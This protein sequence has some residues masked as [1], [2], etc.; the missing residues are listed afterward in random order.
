MNNLHAESCCKDIDAERRK[1]P[2]SN[3]LKPAI[4]A[5]VHCL[6]GC[7]IGEFIGLTFG[8]TAGLAPMTTMFLSTLL[9]FISGF[10]LTVFPLMRNAKLDFHSA[11]KAV[12]LGE[13]I[14]IGIMELV[15]N[16]VDYH[17]GGVRSGS[18]A[19]PLFW[20]ALFFAVPAGFIAALPV[21]AILIAKQMKK[22]H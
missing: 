15:M 14:S 13:L 17:M 12:W 3:S 10:S 11:M 7:M 1:P 6:T 2:D 8:V 16:S 9:A 22:C 4:H 20:K 19:S 5:T 21:N 18:V